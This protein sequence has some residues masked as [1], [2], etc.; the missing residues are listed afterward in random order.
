MRATIRDYVV[1]Y[2]SMYVYKYIFSPLTH[3]FFIMQ[4]VYRRILIFI[5]KVNVLTEENKSVE[6]VRVWDFELNMSE[7]VCVVLLICRGL[8][9]IMEPQTDVLGE[10]Y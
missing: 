8:I 6:T 10:V 4:P 2:I 1:E 7:H 9:R 3:Y 5:V